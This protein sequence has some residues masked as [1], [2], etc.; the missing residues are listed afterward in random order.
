MKKVMMY[1]AENGTQFDNERDCI[2][3]EREQKA[4]RQEIDNLLR[5][6]M[7]IKVICGEHYDFK[8]ETGGHPCA[9]CPIW[10]SENKMLTTHCPF[11]VEEIYDDAPVIPYDWGLE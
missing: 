2:L 10:Q 8:G 4:K 6:A 3:Y 1:I 11:M 9:S 5:S 7:R